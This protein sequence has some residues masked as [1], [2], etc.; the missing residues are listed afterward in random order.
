MGKLNTVQNGKGSK[1]RPGKEI[2]DE[3]WRRAMRPKEVAEL[4][5]ADFSESDALIKKNKEDGW[6][7]VPPQW[8]EYTR[9]TLCGRNVTKLSK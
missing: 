7:E 3:D 5:D 6:P 9:K 1:P 2:S 4:E 8:K